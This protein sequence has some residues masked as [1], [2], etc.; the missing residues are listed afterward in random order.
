MIHIN[1]LNYHY[2]KSIPI[3]ENITCT[4]E[5]GRIYG[6]LGLNGEGKTT[7]MKLLSGLIFPKAGTI[8]L[9][10]I[11]STSRTSAFFE[12]IYFL[13]DQPKSKNMTLKDFKN[14]Y[15]I[16]YK[17]F[18][19][20]FFYNALK[21][22]HLNKDQ[23]IYDLSFGQ[24]KKLH[25]AFALSTNTNFL[26]LDEPT[27]G[28]DIPSKSIF[29]QL[30]A[31]SSTENKTTIISTH[32]VNDIENLLDHLLILHNRKLVFNYSIGD[33]LSKYAFIHTPNTLVNAVYSENNISTHKN[34][35]LNEEDIESKAD[36]ELLFNAVTHNKI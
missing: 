19:N 22:F 29:R 9:N 34:I 27:N 1:N 2:K 11:N 5:S 21:E 10:N 7:L 23:K 30:L 28:L 26:F 15:G 32:L 14:I 16:F 13:P 6:L 18:S 31:K 3:L 36:I 24:E 33:I 35:I 4:L 17:N 25:L 12:E 20:D 8:S